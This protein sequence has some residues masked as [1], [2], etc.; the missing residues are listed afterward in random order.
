MTKTIE[1]LTSRVR[2]LEEQYEL[3]ANLANTSIDRV[4]E[5]EEENARLKEALDAY[6]AEK[7]KCQSTKI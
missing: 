5:L 4:R 7:L 3:A 2:E 6:V 1:Q